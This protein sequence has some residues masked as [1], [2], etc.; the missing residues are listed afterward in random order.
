MNCCGKGFSVF[1]ILCAAGC[2]TQ[3]PR[4][5]LPGDR[6]FAGAFRVGR[7]SGETNSFPQ[8]TVQQV[9]DE[10]NG[11]FCYRG[12]PIHPKLVREFQCW[13]SD[14]NP[15]TLA[16]DVSSA[17]D[18]NEYSDEVSVEDGRVSFSDEEGLFSY[19]HVKCTHDG[20]HV[21]EIISGGSGSYVARDTLWVKFELGQGVYPDGRTYDQLILRLIRFR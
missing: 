18:S 5:S 7:F 21:L 8:L 11:K 9:L 4:A 3:T 14:L 12:K 6:I 15:V 10:A 20:V 13:D 1:L 2:S 17:F 16:V 19:R